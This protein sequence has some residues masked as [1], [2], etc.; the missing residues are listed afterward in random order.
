MVNDWYADF[1]DAENVRYPLLHSANTGAGG[2]VRVF[3]DST[4]DRHVTASRRES[5]AAT[6]ATRSRLA[7]SVAD[8]QAG[9]IPLLSTTKGTRCS[10]GSW[11]WTRRSSSVGKGARECDLAN[12]RRDGRWEM[13]DLRCEMGDGA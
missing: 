11:A 6:H 9:M 12:E 8:A 2:N 1:P 13:G 3:R 5:D 7:N 4:F 10:R